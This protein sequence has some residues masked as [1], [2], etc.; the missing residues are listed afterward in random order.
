MLEDPCVACLL[1][2]S[3]SSC[4]SCDCSRHSDYVQQCERQ[5]EMYKALTA[6]ITQLQMFGYKVVI[7]GMD[8]ELHRYEVIPEMLNVYQLVYVSTHSMSDM[9]TL[10]SDLMKLCK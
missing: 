5:E 3:A 6:L 8:V 10:L 1:K 2:S 7:K 9:V 4:S